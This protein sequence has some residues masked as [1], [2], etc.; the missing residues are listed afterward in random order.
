MSLAS[1]IVRQ[2]LEATLPPGVPPSFSEIVGASFFGSGRGRTIH[3]KLVMIDGLPGV[4]RLSRWAMGWS[5]QWI[6]LPGGDLSFEN[7]EW[8][9]IGGDGEPV[10]PL[11]AS[12]PSPSLLEGERG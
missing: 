5:H 9:R 2:T 11:F 6:D 4:V 12:L 3:A 7:G 8:V 10:L 1:D